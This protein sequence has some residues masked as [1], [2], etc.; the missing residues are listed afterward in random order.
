M[1]KYALVNGR[2]NEIIELGGTSSEE[3]LHELIVD[4]GLATRRRRRTL[5][6]EK[7][8]YIG[9]A[10]AKHS[11]YGYATVILLAEQIQELCK[12]EIM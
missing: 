10:T 8:R 9:I 1:P 7:Y 6:D 11:I 2:I 5:L 3:V 4:D 12:K